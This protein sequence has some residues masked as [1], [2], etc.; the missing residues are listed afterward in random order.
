MHHLPK[1]TQITQGAHYIRISGRKIILV[2]L[3]NFFLSK[4]CYLLDI[5]DQIKLSKIG[6]HR[7]SFPTIGHGRYPPSTKAWGA[8]YTVLSGLH[9]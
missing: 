9:S 6:G 3:F 8:H 4:I 2:P 1:D 7:A 5:C